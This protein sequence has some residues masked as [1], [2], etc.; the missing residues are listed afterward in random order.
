MVPGRVITVEI[1]GVLKVTVYTGQVITNDAVATWTSMDENTSIGGEGTETGER[2][3]QGGVNDYENIGRETIQIS[4]PSPGKSVVET[5]EIFTSTNQVAIGEIVRYRTEV[6][7]A[8]GTSKDV[9]LRDNIPDGLMFINDGTTKVIF[10]STALGN[11]VSQ[12]TEAG[13]ITGITDGA[14]FT[15]GPLA[16]ITPSFVL[17]DDYIS[18]NIGTNSD[19]YGSGTDGGL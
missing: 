6:R 3:G 8:E 12:D 10:V 9:I 5:S 4:E 11:L 15:T 1:T 13:D 19:T 17:T 14:A 2:T 16:S 7:L 18:D